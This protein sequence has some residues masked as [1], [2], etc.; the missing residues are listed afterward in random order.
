MVHCAYGNK[1]PGGLRRKYLREVV[2]PLIAVYR[3]DMLSTR[4]SVTDSVGHRMPNSTPKP[5]Q[6]EVIKAESDW[7]AGTI[8]SELEGD[9]DQFAKDSLQLLKFHGTY[10]QDDRDRRIEL[11]KLGKGKAFSMMIRCRIPGGRMT[12]EQFLA[13]LDICEMLG[14]STMKITTRQ[15]I[16][17]HGVVKRDL[18]ETIQRINSIGL[19]TLAACGDVNRNV[20]C[21]PAKRADPIR[22]ELN[23]LTDDLAESLAPR[24]PAY[25]ELWIKD[26]DNGEVMQ[27]AGNRR[28][29]ESVEPLYGP[30]YL[31]RKFKCGVVLPEDNCIDVYTQDLGF[32]AVVRDGAIIGYNVIVG[33]GMGMTPS[34][35]K[36]FPAIAQR[37]AFCTTDQAIDVAKA[38]LLVQR[39]NGDRSDR[40]VARMKYLV[41]R[42]GVERFRKEVESVLGYE[43][44]NCTEDDVRGVDDHMGWQAQKDGLWSYGLCIENGRVRDADSIDLKSALRELA[45]TL[46]TEI[47]LA[48]NQSLIF[49]DITSNL[50]SSVTEILNR[51]GVR[52]S[53]QFSLVR[54]YSMACVALPSCGLAITEAE[55]RLPSV[56]DELET[57]LAKLGLNADRFTIRMT[58]CPNGCARPYVADVALVGKA[59]D[60]YTIYVGGSL[61]G[62]R[63]AFIH[64]DMV[65]AEQIHDE[66]AALFTVYKRDRRIGECLGDFCHR[67]GSDLLMKQCDE[68]LNA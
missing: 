33:G 1:Q 66:L 12:A 7:L 53:E 14:N 30:T 6:V 46:G 44:A 59:V 25:Q 55:R 11:R 50:R 42:W 15:T 31:P 2:R 26:E 68:I 45:T 37:M 19:S 54:R 51:H 20:M 22:D 27:V 18:R 28:P 60:C 57:S 3:S 4:K 47:R 21:C 43:L 8:Q 65:H 32:I 58:G 40:K 52:A 49:C 35:K 67:A 63:L 61:L 5:N 64:R 36:T 13:H 9:G 24:T 23:R 29:A 48:G 10:Q 56:I 39:D 62:N 41:A 34:S 38:V 16:Q 17:L